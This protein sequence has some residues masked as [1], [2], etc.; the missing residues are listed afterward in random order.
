M[1]ITVKLNYYF[2]VKFFSKRGFPD[3]TATNGYVSSLLALPFALGNAFGPAASSAL[4]EEVGFEYASLAVIGLSCCV[5][6]ECNE[7][8]YNSSNLAIL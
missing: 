3:T 7:L 6:S 8:L 5:V 1:R 2:T 4:Y